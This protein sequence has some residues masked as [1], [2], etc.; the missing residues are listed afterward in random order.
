MQTI[1]SIPF[2]CLFW[3]WS[4]LGDMDVICVNIFLF[5]ISSI[6]GSLFVPPSL[7]IDMVKSAKDHLTF[8]EEV[9]KVASQLKQPH[10]I[11]NAVRRYEECWLKLLRENE[12]ET[13]LVPPLDVHWAWHV[14][15]LC[16]K[17]YNTDINKVK[18]LLLQHINLDSLKLL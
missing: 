12:S 16:P 1:Y 3:W 2:T 5:Q 8:L 15:M 11:A 7:S 17:Q 10:I 9:N 6:M 14:H 18:P 4:P 13:D